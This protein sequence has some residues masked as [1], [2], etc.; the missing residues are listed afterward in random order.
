MVTMDRVPL[1]L[2]GVYEVVIEAVEEDFL[3][4][5]AKVCAH[6]YIVCIFTYTDIVCTITY[7]N[8]KSSS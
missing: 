4:D 3:M 5:L 1:Q 2:G 6:V 7:T 8:C